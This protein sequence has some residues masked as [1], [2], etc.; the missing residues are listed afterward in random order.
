MRAYCVNLT[1]MALNGM[2]EAFAY[3]LA[4]QKVLESLQGLLIYN[5]VIYVLAVL[6]FSNKFGVIGL[7]YANCINMAVRGFCS[8]MISIDC[9]NKEMQENDKK[10]GR[11]CFSLFKLIFNIFIHKFF[12]AMMVLSIVGTHLMKF[13]LNYAVK[14]I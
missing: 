3:G 6:F 8:L 5:S 7:V 1:F 11:N 10:S 12:I 4:N 9:M 2:S 13:L 14:Y